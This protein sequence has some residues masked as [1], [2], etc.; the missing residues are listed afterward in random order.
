M[1]A[2]R[3]VRIKTLGDFGQRDAMPVTA[4]TL[5]DRIALLRRFLSET[6]DVDV[7]RNYPQ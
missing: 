6:V 7:T 4:K 5:R 1:A 2:V 3:S